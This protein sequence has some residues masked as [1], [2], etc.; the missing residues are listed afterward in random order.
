MFK[1]FIRNL[2]FYIR[3]PGA[4]NMTFV[5]KWLISRNEI[6]LYIEHKT[7]IKII[8]VTETILQ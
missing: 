3:K 2:L 5:L 4:F 7:D 6:Q 8:L 1:L